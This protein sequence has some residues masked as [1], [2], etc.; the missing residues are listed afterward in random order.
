M[1]SKSKAQKLEKSKV[2][3]RSIREFVNQWMGKSPSDMGIEYGDVPQL[4]KLQEVFGEPVTIIGA[5]ERSGDNGIYLILFGQKEDNGEYFTVPCGSSV[6][7]KKIGLV[8]IHG[9][10]PV[11]GKFVQPDGKRYFDFVPVE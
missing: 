9:G 10:F 8:K 2:K 11:S 3:A 1:N 4:S 7:I 5:T 6:V